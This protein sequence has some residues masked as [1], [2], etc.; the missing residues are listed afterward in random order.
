M[1]SAPEHPQIF[2]VEESRDGAQPPN[3]LKSL[4]SSRESLIAFADF[5]EPPFPLEIDSPAAWKRYTVGCGARTEG[6]DGPSSQDALAVGGF[7]CGGGDGQRQSSPVGQRLQRHMQ[8]RTPCHHGQL[9]QASLAK[10][11]KKGNST[12]SLSVVCNLLAR[13]ESVAGQIPLRPAASV[14]G[15]RHEGR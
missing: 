3:I 12:E 1:T 6:L 4:T 11:A 14:E 10:S 9:H 15:T 5:G 13:K 7:W 8:G 2:D